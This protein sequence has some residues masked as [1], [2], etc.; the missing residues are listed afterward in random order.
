MAAIYSGSAGPRALVAERYAELLGR[1]L[2]AED[3]DVVSCDPLEAPC[4]AMVMPV[5]A[6]ERGGP[7][8]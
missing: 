8:F 3:G 4:G 1:V 7:G 5:A 2:F 6:L